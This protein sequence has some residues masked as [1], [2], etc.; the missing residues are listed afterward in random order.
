MTLHHP[1]VTYSFLRPH[2]GINDGVSTL[3]LFGNNSQRP[4]TLLTGAHVLR[5]ATADMQVVSVSPD[6][7]NNESEM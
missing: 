1:A 7:H 4:C 3:R 2:E 5:L 6:G